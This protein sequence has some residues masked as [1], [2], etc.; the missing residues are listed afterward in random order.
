MCQQPDGLK[1]CGQCHGCQL[2]QANTHP[3]WY[4]LEAEKGKNTLGIDA[5]RQVTEKMYHFGQQG[6]AKV[7]WLPDA[8]QL[9]E[10][11]ANA[12]LKTLEEPPANSWFFLSSRDPSRL[13]ATLRSRC[14]TLNLSPPDEGQSLH[15]LKKQSDQDE[16]M[17]VT[18][19]RLSA[20]APEA[21]LNLLSAGPW[22]ARQKLCDALPAALQQD[23]L[24]LLPA[25]NADDAAVRIG[26]L[27]SLLLDAM[28]WQQNAGQWLS[29]VDRQDV[30]V[31]L[32]E[33]FT[34]TA[35]NSSAQGWMRC[36]EQL[37]HVA[38]VN[39]ELLLTDQLLSWADNMK[40][41]LIG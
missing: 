37:L 11:A 25:L 26:W 24:H 36:R 2:M 19:L 31:L 15:W 4:R 13:L 28:K 18:A 16:A 40:P 6:G 41:A 8:A 29:N 9:S 17:L 10:A 1:S 32:A 39:R 22:Q 12:L 23:I 21:A 5:V 3:D 34:S 14:M 35:L 20:G 38:A 7:V 33:H 30:V 27:L